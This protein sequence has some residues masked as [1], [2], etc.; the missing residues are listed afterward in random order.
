VLV[1]KKGTVSVDT[2]NAADAAVKDNITIVVGGLFFSCL[3][4]GVFKVYYAAI[5][6]AAAVLRCLS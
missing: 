2:K 4:P 1:S 6:T 5:L 3:V